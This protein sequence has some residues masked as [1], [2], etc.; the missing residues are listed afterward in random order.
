ML[1]SMGSPVPHAVQQSVSVYR[2][3]DKGAD[4]VAW[5]SVRCAGSFCSAYLLT[6]R[7]MNQGQSLCQ[8]VD[9]LFCTYVTG[10]ATRSVLWRYIVIQ[11]HVLGSTWCLTSQ[12]VFYTVRVCDRLNRQ[13]IGRH[14]VNVMYHQP[15]GQGRLGMCLGLSVRA[16]AVPRTQGQHT[17]DGRLLL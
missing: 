10:C 6:R 15:S 11:C 14:E 17:I 2:C 5:H 3:C 1:Q 12:T 9:Q 7:Q 8:L 16:T 4:I 13:G